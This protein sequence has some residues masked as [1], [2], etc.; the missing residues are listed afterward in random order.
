MF[1]IGIEISPAACRIVEIDR[2]R[3][4]DDTIVRSFT[5]A[6][7]PDSA[8]LAPYRRQ[9]V[10]VVMWGLPAD[11]RQAVVTYGSY[12]RMRREAVNATRQAGVD[13]RQM[14]ADIVPVTKGRDGSRRRPV[15]VALARAN[16]IAAALRP[17]TSAGVKV[18]S[19]VT[20]ALAL[21]SLARL[22]YRLVAAGM[23]EA[24]VAL[25]ETTTAIALVRDGALIA[26]RELQWGFQDDHRQIR[27]R[28][29]VSAQLG[30]AIQEFFEECG[31]RPS[32]A[33]QVCVCG[34][35]PDLRSMT[36][37][38]TQGLDVEVEPLD[39]LFG[40][41]AERLPTGIEDFRDRAAEMRL[42]WAAAADWD[43]PINFLRERRRRLAKT[44][45]TRA[46][47]V[48]GVATGLGIAWRIGRSA[49]LEPATPASKPQA[50]ATVA[51]PAPPKPKPTPP[52]IV[53]RPPQ[54]APPPIVQRSPE[55]AAQAPPPVIRVPAAPPPARAVA[56]PVRAA[57]PPSTL[58]AAPPP[59]RAAAL[60]PA[61]AATP[62][63][64][65]VATPPARAAIPP[66]VVLSPVPEPARRPSP[67]EPVTSSAT[68]SSVPANSVNPVA[69]PPERTSPVARP[70]TPK[71]PPADEV[72]LPFEAALGTILYG[73]DRKLAIIDG[74]I[75]QVGDEV[76]GAKVVEI[77]QNS[78]FFRDRQGRLRRLSL[79]D[80]SR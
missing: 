49:L 54:V 27:S 71:T 52:L 80:S 65:P 48:A 63:P 18:R 31:A 46:A 70:P 19:I 16:E 78:V 61:R 64:A 39:S 26:G 3:G 38:L 15:V 36:L 76:R 30:A 34:G 72:P 69:Q 25:E 32:A 67:R 1:R 53:P 40:I 41:D 43:A 73:A 20:P 51:G 62:P 23:I 7:G 13:T 47:V 35:M 50:K 45:L 21:M 28:D 22:R 75:V 37:A 42:A 17:F 9:R 55:V 24:Y 74:R 58:A 79:D 6:A 57:T 66:S 8:T 44:I 29:E 10:A 5:R 59:A 56:P 77:T 2:T 11:H 33:A 14:L 68:A 4:A 60:P 12:Q